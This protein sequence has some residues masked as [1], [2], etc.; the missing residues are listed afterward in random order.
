MENNST[1]SLPRK[2]SR[3]V[4]IFAWFILIN[5]V[6]SLLAFK[7]SAEINPPISNVLFIP[8]LLASITAAIYILKLREWAR[9][10][11]IVLSIVVVVE[12]LATIPYCINRYME[13][14]ARDFDTNYDSG[15]KT[16][17]QQFGQKALKSGITK[18]QLLQQMEEKRSIIK[19]I[20]LKGT[21]MMMRIIIVIYLGFR[22]GAIYFFTRPKVK[23]QF[24]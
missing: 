12:T 8:I 6:A 18:E 15:I 7:T 22:G 23:E 9:V 3:G 16:A 11:I 20:T 19:G 17:L 5:S 1:G 10:M 24:K 21:N 13:L 4:T 2:R 14:I